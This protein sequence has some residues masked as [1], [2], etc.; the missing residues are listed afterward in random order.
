MNYLNCAQVH[1]KYVVL[2]NNHTF[3]YVI[4]VCEILTIVK[5]F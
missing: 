1:I 5:I 4:M 2:Q 3:F